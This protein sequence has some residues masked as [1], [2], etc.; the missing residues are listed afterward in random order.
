MFVQLCVCDFDIVA[1][2][3]IY[4]DSDSIFVFVFAYVG[5]QGGDGWREGSLGASETTAGGRETPK[6]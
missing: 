4:M 1:Y 6:G 5:P 2:V 3:D